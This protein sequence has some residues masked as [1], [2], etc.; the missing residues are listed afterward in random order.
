MGREMTEKRWKYSSHLK[1]GSQKYAAQVKQRRRKQEWD[2]E[3]RGRLVRGNN[4]GVESVELRCGEC[5]GKAVV[6]SFLMGT[7]SK[8]YSTP[9]P[10]SMDLHLY[11]VWNNA[12]S[13]STSQK[14]R[15]KESCLR[16]NEG[17]FYTMLETT[18]NLYYIFDPFQR[19]GWLCFECLDD[20]LNGKRVIIQLFPGEQIHYPFSIASRLAISL[21]N[22]F[23]LKYYFILRKYLYTYLWS[24]DVYGVQIQVVQ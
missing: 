5:V 12:S 20:F 2:G 16:R 23:E 15:R 10:F 1:K 21:W 4:R 13:S 8:N 18:I 6:P 14:K 22:I 19:T 7:N 24:K 17:I 3:R 9:N 11:I